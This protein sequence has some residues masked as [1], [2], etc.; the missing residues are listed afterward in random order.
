[1]PHTS[2]CGNRD[3]LVTRRYALAATGLAGLSTI[4]P[5]SAHA[6]ERRQDFSM[7]TPDGL[8]KPRGYSQAAVVRAGTLV[9]LAGQVPTNITGS[10]IGAGE[11]RPQLEQVFRNLNLGITGLGGTFRNIIKLNYFCVQAVEQAELRH[12]NE[13]RDS[14]IDIENPPVSTFLFVSRLARPE[15]MIEIEAVAVLPDP[16]K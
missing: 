6:Q 4:M 16:S 15:W 2:E 3:G 1:M 9:Y 8:R 5:L 7:V 12:V 14:Y 10:L 11:F 13:V